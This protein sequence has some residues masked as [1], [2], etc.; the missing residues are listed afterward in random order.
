MRV[1]LKEAA[2]MCMA[3]HTLSLFRQSVG[4]QLLFTI[5]LF[6]PK[7]KDWGKFHFLL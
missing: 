1:K 6:P 4:G 3:L 7:K 2:A 5:C